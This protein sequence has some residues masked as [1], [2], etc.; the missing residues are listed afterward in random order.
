MVLRTRKTLLFGC[1]L[2]FSGSGLNLT[3]QTSLFRDPSSAAV[4]AVQPTARTQPAVPPAQKDVVARWFDMTNLM[5]TGRYRNVVNSQG[6]HSYSESQQKVVTTG[7]F[8]MDPAGRYGIGFHGSTGANFIS[9][10][11]GWPFYMRRLYLDAK[12]VK[13][14]ELQYGFLDLNRGVN[15]EITSYDDDGFIAGERLVVRAPKKT[16]V[17]EF[18]ATWAYLGDVTEIDL[19]HRG[20]RLGHSN[21]HQ[22]LLRKKFD[23]RAEASADYTWQSGA[24]TIREAVKVRVPESKIFDTV[25]LEGY[26]RLNSIIPEGLKTRY[27]RDNGLAILVNKTLAQ[28]Y[29][30]QAGF[31]NVDTD[32]DVTTALAGVAKPKWSLA[33][34]Q[35][36]MGKRFIF[37]PT[38]KLYRGLSINGI[39]TEAFDYGPSQS[40]VIWNKRSVVGAMSY[41][42]R[43]LI[44]RHKQ[45]Q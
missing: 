41:D 42:F 9:S 27:R 13:Q 28:R 43:T 31:M 10:W 34:D 3:A 15:T 2:L 36:N 25:S 4:P 7:V 39:L 21:Y 6:K 45:I 5:M 29:T 26:E 30:L 17:D 16:G 32:Y 20:D 35:Y 33:G 38:I 11:G 8:L 22:L 19:F 23:K 12:P 37:R 18:S 14:L 44:Y 1:V 24:N 40:K